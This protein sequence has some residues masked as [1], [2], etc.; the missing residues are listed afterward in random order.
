LLKGAL[1]GRFSKLAI[2][3]L[4]VALGQ[5][6][7]VLGAI[8]AARLLTDVLNPVQYGEVA[9]AATAGSLVTQVSLGPLHQSALRFFGPALE[10]GELRA[11]LTATWRLAW[12]AGEVVVLGSVILGVALLLLGYGISAGLAMGAL[13]LALVS[14]YERLLDALQAAG[15]QRAITAWHQGLAQWLRLAGALALVTWLGASS[16]LVILGYVFATF[17][18]LVS[19]FAFFR[20]RWWPVV[21]MSPVR[22]EH[23]EKW[24]LH[25]RTY[26]RPFVMWGG[27]LWL[28]QSS[29]RWALQTFTTTQDVGYYSVL[30]QL[31]YAPVILLTGIIVQFVQPIF[32]SRSGD[33]SDPVRVTNALRLNERLLLGF[34]AVTIVGT[35]LAQLVH[36]QVFG[37]LVAADYRSVSWLMP[38]M[39]L[40]GGL[41][42]CSEFAALSLLTSLQAMKLRSIRIAG[43]IAG[44][45]L[46]ITGAYWFGLTGVVCAS[47]S[48]SMLNLVWIWLRRRPS[49][50]GPRSVV[51][52]SAF[53]RT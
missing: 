41:F 3:G 7:A 21:S 31:G 11:C 48:S 36:R 29:D 8:V 52:S 27:F 10:A 43:A 47:V 42:A 24:R 37:L 51:N 26:A 19:Q 30:F 17:L 32:F 18:V 13:I 53:T 49:S 20:R 15:R 28:Q 44:I 1:S 33:G 9:L 34:L 5:G 12:R 6:V 39:L 46:N 4:Q 35:V 16:A 2:E 40:S 22:P 38:W 14:G 45:G 23:V 50:P 25:L